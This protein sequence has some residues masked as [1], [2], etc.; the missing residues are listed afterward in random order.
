VIPSVQALAQPVGP[1]NQGQV[2]SLV[3]KLNE[4]VTKLNSGE[5][6]TACNIL[7]ASVNE[8]NALVQGGVLTQA[9]A[10]TILN[11]PTGLNAVISA[12]PC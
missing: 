10:N 2:H 9:Q 12:I 7:N 3:A 6:K 11:G 1:L 4:A 8:L 5:T